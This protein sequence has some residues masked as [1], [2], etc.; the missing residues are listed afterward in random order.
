MHCSTNVAVVAGLANDVAA[1]E[2][3]ITSAAYANHIMPS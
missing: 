2:N 1:P 3:C